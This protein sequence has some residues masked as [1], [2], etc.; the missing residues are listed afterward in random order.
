MKLIMY[1]GDAAIFNLQC[2]QSNGDPL[3]ITTGDL[4]FT[5]KSS[6]RQSDVDA[7]FQKTNGDGVSI[8]DGPNGLATVTLSTE[9]TST[10]YAPSY[11]AWDLQYV[12]TGGQPTTLL[13]GTLLIKAD[14]TRST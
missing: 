10:V 2:L 6:A 12:T 5:A 7:V 9:D 14:V 1:R 13:A 11:L 4:W 8:V 3:D